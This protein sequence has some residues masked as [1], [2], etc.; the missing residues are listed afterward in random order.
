MTALTDEIVG[1]SQRPMCRVISDFQGYMP[2]LTLGGV[3]DHFGVTAGPDEAI[4]R[5]FEYF[6]SPMELYPDV[7]P[8]PDVFARSHR[9]ADADLLGERA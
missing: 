1:V 6:S 5:S 3:C 9:L 4:Q 2:P 8:P 7:I